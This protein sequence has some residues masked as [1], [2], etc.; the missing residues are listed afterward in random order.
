MQPP[1][2]PRPRSKMDSLI[3]M[4]DSIKAA[5]AEESAAV[6]KEPL[7]VSR[8]D[9][10]EK[11]RV[12]EKEIEVEVEAENVERPVDLYKVHLCSQIFISCWHCI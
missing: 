10:E 3:F 7:S 1:P 8:W 11:R 6:N 9:S 12:I 2:P 5:K 4:P